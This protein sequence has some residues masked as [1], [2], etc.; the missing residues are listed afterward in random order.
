MLFYKISCINHKAII[1]FIVISSE[2]KR[3]LPSMKA[4][5]EEALNIS[6]VQ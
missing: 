5:E 2:M 6:S 1:L 3:K 4:E